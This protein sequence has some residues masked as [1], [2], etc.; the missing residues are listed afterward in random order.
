MN[1]PNRASRHHLVRF[2][3]CSGVSFGAFV[4]WLGRGCEKPIREE[5]TSK[6]APKTVHM[7]IRMEAKEIIEN[8]PFPA[9]ALV[10]LGNLLLTV[11]SLDS[12]G[13]RIEGEEDLSTS[14]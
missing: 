5:S 1:I 4:G 9:D 6:E 2:A 12:Y 7:T 8:H 13:L 14:D 3:N 11:A 10:C